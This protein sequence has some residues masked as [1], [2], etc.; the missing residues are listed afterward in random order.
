[1]RSLLGNALKQHWH[2][3]LS[4][5]F[6]VKD[7]GEPVPKDEMWLLATLRVRLRAADTRPG[8]TTWR[9]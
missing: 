2:G 6:V 4:Q 5:Q 3:S 1:V 9:G 8:L 7:E